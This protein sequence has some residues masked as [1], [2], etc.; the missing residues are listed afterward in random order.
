MT[1]SRSENTIRTWSIYKTK[2]ASG[3]SMNAIWFGFVATAILILMFIILAILE[4]L[5]RSDHSSYYDGSADQLQQ[6]AQ[7]SSMIPVSTSDVSV[8]MPGEKL[9]SYIA[10]SAP[11]PC[12]R[13]GI[14]WPP[15][16]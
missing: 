13:E 6:H 8:V 15:H 14:R 2:D 3:P 16:L 9:P 5:F 11:F 10:L 12:R 1:E 7:K 4:H